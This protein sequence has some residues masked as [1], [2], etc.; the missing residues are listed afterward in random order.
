MA[1]GSQGGPAGAGP[2]PGQTGPTSFSERVSRLV[3][4]QVVDCTTESVQHTATVVVVGKS[5][6]HPGGKLCLAAWVTHQPANRM[7][8]PALGYAVAQLLERHEYREHICKY[9][10][11]A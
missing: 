8:N 2:D 7:Y 1:I 10:R 11:R 4:N 9:V 5:Q 6:A 3:P